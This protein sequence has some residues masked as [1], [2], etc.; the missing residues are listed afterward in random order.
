M[1]KLN[2]LT[3]ML[4]L[5]AL[6]AGSMSS[7]WAKDEPYLTLKFPDDYNASNGVSNYTST[8]T[9]K[10][11]TFAWSIAN[12]NNNN[13]NNGWTYIRCGKSK[14]ASTCTITTSS[15]IDKAIRY[16]AVT[17]DATKNCTSSKLEVASNST[18]TEN[19]QTINGEALTTGI[20][21]Y[22]I[23]EP[24]ENRYYKLTFEQ[25][26]G[27]NGDTQI[28]QV[29]YCITSAPDDA[30]PVAINTTPTTWNL[31]SS[32][33]GAFSK[34]TSNCRVENTLRATDG[35]SN[36]TY[37]QGKNDELTANCLNAG[38]KSTF[39]TGNNPRYF[40]LHIAK[41]GVLSI[42]SYGS[43]YGNYL[44]YQNSTNNISTA[45]KTKVITTSSENLMASGGISIDD[46]EYVYIGFESQLYTASI[47]WAEADGISLT[48]TDNMDG[49][50]AFY[51]ATQG[52]TL[53][54]NTKAYI[55][56]E[57][58]ASTVKL[59]EIVDVPAGTP[60]ILH[61][62]SSADNHKMTLTKAAST[63][64]DATGNHLAVTD[65][66]DVTN[67]YRLGYLAG[68]GNGVGFY[69]YSATK[70]AAGIVYLNVGVSS[71]DAKGLTFV[72]DDDET[73]GIKAVST[74]VENGVRYNLAGQKV[75]ADYKG[76]VIVNGKKVIIK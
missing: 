60:V 8:W 76:I 56:S 38:G 55:A 16:V 22:N 46:G 23:P 2:V 44:I 34:N 67:K 15:K 52:Y 49:W 65:G 64:G 45:I 31:T 48:T 28:S 9:A 57:T 7:V 70:P 6:L 69:P 33:E 41:S 43:K 37:M 58:T 54:D 39:G 21:R 42:T 74:K 51:D 5:L 32:I 50:R 73:D 71:G 10:T 30:E 24:A 72:F 59:K 1:K 53:D 61:T 11:G 17:V 63:S 12:F 29:A 13:W 19:K 62:S 20:V 25:A 40:V 66:T 4:L 68:D 36:I 18:F 47:S 26:D 75:G 14:S 3:R 35:K 27:S